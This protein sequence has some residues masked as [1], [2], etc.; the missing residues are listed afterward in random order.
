ML[1]DALESVGRGVEMYRTRSD[2]SSVRYQ[3]DL[4]VHMPQLNAFFKK[5]RYRHLNS[6]FTN[7]FSYSYFVLYDQET[8]EEIWSEEQFTICEYLAAVFGDMDLTKIECIID[9]VSV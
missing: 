7:D 4:T 1:R 5:Y 3:Y 8:G 2:D 6:A 9:A